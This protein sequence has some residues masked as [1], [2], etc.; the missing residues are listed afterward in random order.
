MCPWDNLVNLAALLDF[1]DFLPHHQD[2]N[3]LISRAH[4]GCP[5]RPTQQA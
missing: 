4:A 5:Y 3:I 1:D 2:S